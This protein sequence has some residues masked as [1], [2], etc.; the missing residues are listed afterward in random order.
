MALGAQAERYFVEDPVTSLMKL[1]QFGER[2]AQR[3]AAHL[4]VR[5]D[6]L[7][8]YELIEKLAS[9]PHNALSAEV[10]SLF[11]EL[12]TRRA[13]PSRSSSRRGGT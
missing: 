10:R 9:P 13:T 11:H 1:R 7:K 3:A 5:S 2:L 12:R 4:N 8:Q 6:N